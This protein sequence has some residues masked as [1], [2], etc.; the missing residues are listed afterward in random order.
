MKNT[1]PLLS[2]IPL[3]AASAL[4]AQPEIKTLATFPEQPVAINT[5]MKQ[6]GWKSKRH[7]PKRF[8]V[9]KGS[10]HLVSNK[11]SVMIGTQR[12]FPV[13]PRKYSKIRF[14]IKIG[15]NPAGT[16]PAIKGGDDSAFRLYLAFDRGGGM[17]S[18]PDSIAYSWTEKRQAAATSV[19]PHYK[20]VRNLYIGHGLTL[21]AKKGDGKPVFVT[22]ERDLLA[23]YKTCFP[24]DSR[25]VP[26]LAGVM[27][28][29]DTNN[30]DTAAESWLSKLELEASKSGGR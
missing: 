23:D 19:S 3:L 18:P 8:E 1:L 15:K 10:L 21:P 12:G 16:N 6:N 17:F 30:T 13:D 27:V 29:C 7:D 22:I 4:T 28:K 14:T 11:D 2:L 20:N 25:A 5:W 9:G 26:M 24:E